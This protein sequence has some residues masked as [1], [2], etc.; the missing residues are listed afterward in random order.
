M[1]TATAALTV[2]PILLVLGLSYAAWEDWRRREV[3]DRVWQ[4][5]GL[6]GAVLGAFALGTRALLPLVMWTI[7]SAFVLEHVVPWDRPVERWGA[8]APLIVEGVLYAVV[9]GVVGWAALR[10]GVGPTTV[11]I[12]V[13]AVVVTV[14]LARALFEMGVLY[15]GA[16]AKAVMIA[17]LVV[18]L[19]AL[20][21]LPLPANAR[22]ILGFYPFSLNLLMDAAILAIVVP[23]A[24]AIQ[25]LRAGTFAFPGGFTSYRIPVAR[26]G[27][28]FVWVRDPALPAEVED[29]ETSEEDAALRRRQQAELTARGITSVTVTPQ[30]PFIVLLAVGG[31]AALLIGNIIFDIAAAL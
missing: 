28:T 11:P 21:L 26:L 14:L 6:A 5:L 8:T 24:L 19:F 1:N 7:A 16:D 15:G 13:V 23:I 3:S 30:L 29:V 2:L 18:P 10:F 27:E 22:A 17:G 20:P 9:L 12:E 25:N 31:I 4:V